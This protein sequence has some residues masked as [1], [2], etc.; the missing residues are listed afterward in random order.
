MVSRIEHPRLVDRPP[1]ARTFRWLE[2]ITED[3]NGN[4]IDYHYRA[5]RDSPGVLYLAGVTY[6]A[7]GTTDAFHVVELRTETRPDRLSDYRSTFERRW[8]RRYREIS[9]GSY[10]DGERHPVRAYK[11][12]YDP[13]DG[14]LALEMVDARGIGL[15]IS[16]LHAVIPFGADRSWGGTG[17]PGTPLPPTRF[18]YALPTLTQFSTELK[19][20]L[21]GLNFRSRPHEPDPLVAGP[22]V[23]QLMQETSNGLWNTIFDT[24]LRDPRVQFADVDGD[25][26]VDILDTR[27]DWKKRTYTVA[28]NVGAGRFRASRPVHNPI[29][30]HLGQNT[31]TNQTFLSDTDGD[32]VIDLV[33]ITGESAQRRTLICKN[34]ARQGLAGGAMRENLGFSGAAEDFIIARNTPKEVDTTD[35][36]VRQ[37]DLNF[38]K[39]S[40][41]LVWSEGGLTGYFATSE[42]RWQVRTAAPGD[43]TIEPSALSVATGS[44]SI[45]R[46]AGESRTL[47][48]NWRI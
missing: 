18:S 24:P 12:S 26:L 40:D 22:V 9:V 25:G 34:L 15:G 1:F 33:Q 16:A 28:R 13:I 48:F 27:V 39:I 36:A 3:A 45:C 4:R 5:H 38:D 37:I 8:S 10:F 19:V 23:G 32:G 17:E 35:P 43:G 14:A 42:G 41:V 29:G 7:A 30:L 44:P 6:R 31:E 2:D 20:R 47:W 46:M 21:A 11:L